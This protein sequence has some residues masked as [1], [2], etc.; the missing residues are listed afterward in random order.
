[1][2]RIFSSAFIGIIVAGHANAKPICAEGE[3]LI[4]RYVVETPSKLVNMY[5][6]PENVD[7]EGNIKIEVFGNS[8]LVTMPA[9]FDWIPRPK[10]YKAPKTITYTETRNMSGLRCFGKE[11]RPLFLGG[12]R[13]INSEGSTTILPLELKGATEIKSECK[14]II[15]EEP[16]IIH[17]EIEYD[18]S[19]WEQGDEIKVLRSPAKTISNRTPEIYKTVKAEPVL[20]GKS[21]R[22]ATLRAENICQ[23]KPSQKPN[24]THTNLPVTTWSTIYLKGFSS[25]GQSLEDHFESLGKPYD[26]FMAVLTT[27]MDPESMDVVWH[28]FHSG[29][30]PIFNAGIDENGAAERSK[31]PNHKW[32]PKESAV[33]E[34]CTHLLKNMQTGDIVEKTWGSFSVESIFLNQVGPA[35]SN[36]MIDHSAGILIW[37]DQEGEEIARFQR[38][39]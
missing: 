6:M 26:L 28:G 30:N 25:E 34:A 35:K 31:H 17:H 38:L 29:C 10:D 27:A 14:N 22:P 21:R 16:L 24:L 8:E 12:D 1:M 37:Y 39:D 11:I 19:Y 23:I 32:T 20:V 5:A 3:N 4:S 13:L 9:T 36:H 15:I 2:T 18:P 33:K 7:A